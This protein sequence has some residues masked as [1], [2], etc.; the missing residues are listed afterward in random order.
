MS[1]TSK[2]TI[3]I[4]TIK[5]QFEKKDFSTKLKLIEASFYKDTKCI[6]H[7]NHIIT[8]INGFAKKEEMINNANL[9]NYITKTQIFY[10]ESYDLEP[11]IEYVTE[12]TEDHYE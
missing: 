12:Q 6:V 1:Q 10:S 11:W 7:K 2:N 5:K 8:I 3:I 9:K 4:L